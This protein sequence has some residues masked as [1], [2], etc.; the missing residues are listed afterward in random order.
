MIYREKLLRYLD[1]IKAERLRLITDKIEESVP[2][3]SDEEAELGRLQND[4]T[5]IARERLKRWLSQVKK[6]S[7]AANES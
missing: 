7:N 1:M 5:V 3:S 6:V 4:F 2:L